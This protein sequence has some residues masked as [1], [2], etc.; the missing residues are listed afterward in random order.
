VVGGANADHGFAG[1]PMRSNEF[2][3]LLRQ[4]EAAGKNDHDVRLRL[5]V[6]IGERPHE[7]FANQGSVGVMR[8]EFERGGIAL[9]RTRVR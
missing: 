7:V 3:L 2:P 4:G 5:Q 1:F 9:D 8:G 6:E